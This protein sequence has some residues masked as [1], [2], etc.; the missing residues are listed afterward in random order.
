MACPRCGG[1]LTVYQLADAQSVA[2]DDC[3]YVG[4]SVDHTSDAQQHES[5]DDAIERFYQGA[6][7]VEQ[8][9]E[10]VDHETVPFSDA[11][12]VVEELI[13][14]DIPEE[15]ILMPADA[16]TDGDE[17]G[18]SETA[19]ADEPSADETPAADT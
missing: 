14:E 15:D 8:V 4:V 6:K 3:T 11:D 13:D 19:D 17:G 12:A 2:C 1:S 10:L 18:E 9:K 5:W 16:G 7:S